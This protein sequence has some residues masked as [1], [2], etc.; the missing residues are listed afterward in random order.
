MASLKLSKSRYCIIK[1]KHPSEAIFHQGAFDGSSLQ[2]GLMI[3]LSKRRWTWDV[4][5]CREII[6]FNERRIH[7]FEELVI[8][9][10][11]EPVDPSYSNPW[12]VGGSINNHGENNTFYLQFSSG[13]SEQLD[14]HKH[15][16]SWFSWEV[17]IWSHYPQIRDMKTEV[18]GT[19]WLPW[20][21]GREKHAKEVDTL[22]SLLSAF[23]IHN[24]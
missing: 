14:K 19:D 13:R 1:P 8:N 9:L 16:F 3:S 15:P 6:A 17:S 21:G 24:T 20:Q 23:W 10:P 7:R 4:C 18:Q 2:R 11:S 22:W 5:I 12:V